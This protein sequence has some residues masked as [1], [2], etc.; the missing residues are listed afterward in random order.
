V[1][2]TSR[3]RVFFF[4]LFAEPDVKQIA[5]IGP[6]AKIAAYSGG[7]SASLL[8]YYAV[9]PYD[10]IKSQ[11]SSY[12]DYA[13][14]YGSYSKLP[15]LSNALPNMTMRVYGAPPSTQSRQKVDEIKIVDTNIF[16]Y[17]YRP[18]LPKSHQGAWYANFTGELKPAVTGD[19][20]F[21]VSV[22][23][24]AKLYIDGKLLVDVATQQ[25]ASG[26]FFGFG[27]TEVTGTTRLEAD[28]TYTVEVEFGSLATSLLPGPGA[29]SDQ[30][31]GVRMGFTKVMDA[32]E[33]IEKAVAVAK[34]VDQVVILTGLN[35]SN[36]EPQ[37]WWIY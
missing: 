11:S 10:A 33:E 12:I 9:T 14:G 3:T 6:N 22:A 35:V 25:T 34:Q 32:E 2:I 4:F 37:V 27:T 16:L 7:G 17:D 28:C 18:P 13:I 1:K 20:Q 15:L 30:G 8:P 19:Y 5:V 23:G 24:T 26:S 31:G 21:S 36:L 29:E